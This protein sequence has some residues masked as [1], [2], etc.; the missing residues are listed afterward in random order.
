[1]YFMKFLALLFYSLS[2]FSFDAQITSAIY[3]DI[4]QNIQGI[5]QTNSSWFISNQFQIYKI[6]RDTKLKEKNF[7]PPALKNYQKIG[8]PKKFVEQGYNHFGGISIFRNYLIVALERKNPMK[9]LFFD[10]ET[11]EFEMAYD[12]PNKLKSLS[13]VAG[14]SDK[15]YFSE[16]R[17]N[18]KHPL[19]VLD[20]D[21]KKLSEI[22]VNDKLSKIQGGTFSKNSNSLFFSADMGSRVGGV[23]Q[24]DLSQKSFHQEVA[25]AYNSGFPA[26]LELEGLCFY[27]ENGGDKITLLLLDNEYFQDA[28]HFIHISD[29]QFLSDRQIYI[30]ATKLPKVN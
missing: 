21:T 10:Q 13:W 6:P 25:V 2:A 26:Y 5:T 28:F 8:I 4:G 7:Y 20:F 9:I 24:F 3:S 11:L 19:Y 22:K 14:S 27:E 17:I 29:Y 23:Y 18:S 16:N 30:D 12:V 15:I 1:M